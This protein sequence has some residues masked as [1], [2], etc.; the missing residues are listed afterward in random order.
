MGG[1]CDLSCRNP[2]AAAPALGRE[3]LASQ[4]CD[5]LSHA[6]SPCRLWVDAPKTLLDE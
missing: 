3:H 6:A 5:L 4:T 1:L 2:G